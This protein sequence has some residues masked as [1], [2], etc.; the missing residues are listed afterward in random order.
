[1]GLSSAPRGPGVLLVMVVSLGDF[2][3]SSSGCG[4]ALLESGSSGLRENCLLNNVTNMVN[5]VYYQAI[6]KVTVRTVWE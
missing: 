3:I 6:L 2:S 4:D 1:M 5:V